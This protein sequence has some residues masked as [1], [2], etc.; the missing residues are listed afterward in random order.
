M[1]EEGKM[2]SD[3]LLGH[4]DGQPVY[5]PHNHRTAHLAIL[6]KTRYGKT[7]LLEHLVLA[8]IRDRT[9][10][11]VVDAHGD[12]TRRLISLADNSARDRIVLVE[13]NADRPFGLNLYECLDPENPDAVT[14]TVDNVIAIFNKLMGQEGPSYRP[15]ID[16]GLRNTARVLIANGYTMAE[17]PRLYTD[18]L[19]R[20][21]A[22]RALPAPTNYWHEYE[23]SDPRRQQEKREP[24]LNKVARF[25]EDGLI[26]PMVSQART[27]IPIREVLS[28][29]GILLLNLSGLAR[30]TV[31]FLGMV[32]LSVVADRLEQRAYV[33]KE[34][35]RR[36]H[37]Y[38]DE[39]GRFATPTTQHMIHD[40]GKYELGIT[41]AHQSLSQSP[42]QEAL[43][44]ETLIAFQLPGDD[45]KLVA[46]QLDVTPVRVRTRL[47]QRTE[48]QY[49][50]WDE[51]VWLSPVLRDQ[52]QDLT[53][54]RNAAAA[55]AE[56]ATR[57][58]YLL[59]KGLNNESYCQSDAEARRTFVYRGDF[60]VKE[61]CQ[62]K[63]SITSQS[64]TPL[65][66]HAAFNPSGSYLEHMAGL[67]DNCT[68]GGLAWYN[69][70]FEAYYLGPIACRF[71]WFRWVIEAAI[72]RLPADVELI[73]PIVDEVVSVLAAPYAN[74]AFRF[75]VMD[76]FDGPPHHTLG[77]E[78][79]RNGPYRAWP[80]QG[81]WATER[82]PT[83]VQWLAQRIRDLKADEDQAKQLEA[84]CQRAYLT[85]CRTEH[86]KEYLGETV[87]T[88]ESWEAGRGYVAQPLY[89]LIEEPAQTSAD[90]AAEKANMLTQ[91]PRY[92]AYCKVADSA[93][94]LNEHRIATL[95]PAEPAGAT[96]RVEQ[97][98][99]LIPEGLN[100][101]AHGVWAPEIEA[102]FKKQDPRGLEHLTSFM[103]V[104]SKVQGRA[105]DSDKISAVRTRSR[106]QYGA[107]R[108]QITREV[109][110]RG[111]ASSS[112]HKEPNSVT[113]S[114]EPVVDPAQQTTRREAT[115]R[116][117]AEQTKGQ[118]PDPKP[119]SIGRRSPP[120]KQ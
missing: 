115:Q 40:L 22:L 27:T 95:S 48:P 80:A 6:G 39:Y 18:P 112:P 26:A 7:T 51:Q 14:R 60:P 70:V 85:G 20:A 8:D 11:I 106:E 89:D 79:S 91:L 23:Q 29:G 94:S 97:P 44:V 1:H 93:G 57:L 3:V 13:P 24:V 76:Y 56:R 37:L 45:A 118:H 102:Y 109:A 77:A 12:L 120:K 42:Q 36:V 32:F 61:I 17:I 113:E 62:G 66:W 105:S 114:A 21:A 34:Q 38:L 19:F 104:A 50:E 43:D 82:F 119:P 98:H 58:L 96:L 10:A 92:V 75:M 88:Q 30:E 4:A 78:R 31:S 65:T 71:S 5:L 2:C 16:Q 54:Q 35:R 63:V 33:P 90:R 49:R 55:K 46:Q 103:R 108:D 86:R 81:V 41:I 28:E 73:K 67:P 15:Y 100:L 117:E 107:L 74:T 110:I 68:D 52:Y 84:Q 64:E 72:E 83:A 101:A 99:T 25:L 111:R 116:K 69:A 87:V 9:A 47:Q 59:D 53:R